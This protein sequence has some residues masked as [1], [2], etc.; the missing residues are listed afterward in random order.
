MIS[1]LRVAFLIISVAYWYFPKD[2]SPNICI[3]CL[4]TRATYLT[5]RKLLDFTART[6]L[7]DQ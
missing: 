1:D 3:P 4:P 5:H 6:T 2:L 7:G